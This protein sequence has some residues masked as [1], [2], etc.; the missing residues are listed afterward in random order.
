[1]IRNLYFGSFCF[2]LF[3]S[4]SLFGQI[5]INE[6]IKSYVENEITKWQQ[7]DEF[8][9]TQQYLSRVNDSSRIIKA[10]EFYNEKLSKIKKEE[11]INLRIT[12]F[13]LG[14]YDADNQTFIIHSDK[15]GE[16][17]VPIKSNKAKLFKEN[18]YQIRLLNPEFEIVNDI[19]A[20]KKLDFYL[21][22]KNLKRSFRMKDSSRPHDLPFNII[23]KFLLENSDAIEVKTYIVDKD[24]ID[25]PFSELNNFLRLYP[26][27][28]PL[29]P[30]LYSINNNIATFNSKQNSSYSFTD[31]KFVFKPIEIQNIES[32]EQKKVEI[33]SKTILVGNS[34][35]EDSIPISLNK[36]EN[37]Y[38]LAV[39]NE[40]YQK[41]QTGL[42]IE[43]NVEFAQADAELFAKYAE[44]ALCI[45]PE[46]ITLIKNATAAQ[47]KREINKLSKLAEKTG[48]ETELIFYYAGH[49]LVNNISS[50]AY[51][52]PVDV[53]S[54]N[55]DEGIMLS[56]LFKQ[57]SEYPSQKVTVFLDACFSG[58]GRNLGLISERGVKI[59]PK[60]DV[61]SGNIVVF[62]SCKGEQTSLLYR[63][64][65]HGL[66]TYHL[67]KKIHDSNANISYG[68]LADYLI[69]QVSI[70]A[71]RINGKEQD[72]NVLYSF[73]VSNKWRSWKFNKK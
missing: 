52:V 17:I 35:I 49:G 38:V 18:W 72:P 32:Y 1:M 47:L 71:L 13:N 12:L 65:G 67:L 28:K 11:A 5:S 42:K 36:Q 7:K 45:P 29:F 44:K 70:D 15:Y 26:K 53:N 31:L 14:L 63:L 23:H 34:E 6:Q 57:L 73:D 4:F 50:S 56:N 41:F 69:K 24:T 39:G 40:D 46:N 25:V 68:E 21:P 30:E 48:A 61:L 19:L 22:D 2:F 60:Y 64:K 62:A 37:V 3:L 8:E 58:G 55:I 27:S 20:I 10:Q 51:I 59:I 33:S 66:F 16:I 43:Q 9:T 54:S